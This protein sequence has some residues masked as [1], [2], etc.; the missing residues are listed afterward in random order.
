[1]ATFNG[2]KPTDFDELA[3]STWRGRNA[4]GGVLTAALKH[5]TGRPYK[6]WGVRRRL[7]LHIAQ[8][9]QYD[10]DYPWPY[11]KLFVYSHQ[12]LA[13]GFY[14]ESPEASGKSDKLEKYIHWSNFKK[15]L[16]HNPAMREALLAAMAN[17]NLVMTDYYRQDRGGALQCKFAFHGGRLQ[18]YRVDSQAWHDIEVDDLV[19][20]IVRLPEDEWVD[21]HVFARIEQQ[22]AIDMGLKVVNPIL[23]VLRALTPVYEAAISSR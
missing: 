7:E 16:Q 14:I 12:E 22:E 21:L 2:F 3:G 10:F 15:S 23:N 6:S 4:L 9:G 18:W 5:Q 1:M 13:F 17:H 20:R 19:R 11:A 8:V